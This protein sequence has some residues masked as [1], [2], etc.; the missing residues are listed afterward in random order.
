MYEVSRVRVSGP[1]A[2]HVSELV[3]YL[4]GRGY[5]NK[6]TVEHVRRLAQVSRWLEREG[7]ELEAVD[8]TLVV[9]LVGALH[10]AGK[11]QSLTPRSFRVLLGFLR[12][13][14][15]VP[16][17]RVAVPTP[18]E[19]LLDGYRNYL[20]VERALAAVTITG[21]MATAGWFVWEA[22]ANDP[23]RVVA[24]S[25]ADVARFV[26]GVGRVRGPRSVNEAVVGVRSMLRYF[27]L[28]G[29]IDRPLAQAAPW[30]AR[31]RTAALPRTLQPGV[32]G[33]LLASCDPGTLVGVRD[34]AV[35]TLF[36]RL[37]LRVGEVTAMEVGDVDWRR[38]E[39][40]VRSKGGWRDPLPLPV[41]VGDA[42]V[43]YL[44]RRGPG[45]ECRQ[46]FLRVR[47]PRGPMAMTDI[48]A[49]VRRAC[50]RVGIADTSTHRLRHGL[51]CD[52]LRHGAP[53]FE[54]GQVLR[55]RDLETTAVYAKVDFAALATVAQ[56]WPGSES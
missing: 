21:Y 37:G 2:A 6:S 56:R 41:D 30:L 3:G 54:I 23:C 14:G 22:C 7:L 13:E 20:V 15:I 19:V 40:T 17:V 18:I 53:L 29:L 4:A 43:A 34:F 33:L 35:L 49:V 12:S 24:L 52:M 48:R 42:L 45:G 9:A 38:G 51:A 16:P 11:G 46:M 50:A 47:A 25:A 32:T 26:V 27:Y 10:V 8:E 36:V 5:G 55:H 31:G 44:S 1:L 39:V 28:K